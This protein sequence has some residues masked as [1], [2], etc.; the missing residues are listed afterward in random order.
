MG[1]RWRANWMPSKI[2]RLVCA[3]VRLP[4]CETCILNGSKSVSVRRTVA[5]QCWLLGGERGMGDRFAV[6]DGIWGFTYVFTCA[7]DACAGSFGCNSMNTDS[8]VSFYFW[9]TLSQEEKGKLK[10]NQAWRNHWYIKTNDCIWNKKSLKFSLRSEDLIYLF[11]YSNVYFKRKDKSLTLMMSFSNERVTHLPRF[12]CRGIKEYLTEEK[13]VKPAASSASPTTITARCSG[14][15]ASQAC[16]STSSVRFLNISDMHVWL[17][18]TGQSSI[19]NHLHTR[20]P[21]LVLRLPDTVRSSPVKDRAGGRTGRDTG[22]HLY[23]RSCDGGS[24]CQS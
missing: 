3:G 7:R 16:P 6:S 4:V 24:N 13:T 18:K 20:C 10:L 12:I 21:S 15:E 23:V 2:T 22:S 8:A 14:G 9:H 19:K 17:I 11:K 1:F 5:K